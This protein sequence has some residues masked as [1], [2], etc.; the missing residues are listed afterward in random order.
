MASHKGLEQYPLDDGH[1][2]VNIQSLE[3]STVILDCLKLQKT[4]YDYV[5]LFLVEPFAEIKEDLGIKKS[6]LRGL[7]QKT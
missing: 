1:D 6:N 3:I 4:K 7:L 2:V 5:F